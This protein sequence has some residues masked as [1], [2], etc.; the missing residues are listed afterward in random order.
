MIFVC[1]ISNTFCQKK[2][3]DFREKNSCFLSSN[4]KYIFNVRFYVNIFCKLNHFN[5]EN[6]KRNYLTL[7]NEK[8]SVYSM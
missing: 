7:F 2:N 4:E 5:K 3:H 8:G 1:F 6:S